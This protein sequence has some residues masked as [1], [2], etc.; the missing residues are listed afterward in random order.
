MSKRLLDFNPLSG[1]KVWFQY[2][3][4]IDSMTITHEQ[5]VEDHLKVAHARAIDDNYTRKGMKNDLLHYAHVP[6]T[7]ILKMKQEDGVDLFEKNDAKRVFE[8]LNTKYKRLKTTTKNHV[9]R[10]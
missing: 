8:L 9:P 6:N 1:E 4:S 2:D 3:E 10:R 7:V 5:D